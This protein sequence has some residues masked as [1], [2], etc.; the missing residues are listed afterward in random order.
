MAGFELTEHVAA[1]P[2]EVFA[3]FADFEGAPQRTSGIDKLE[4]LT[5]GPIGPGTRFRETRTMFG[6]QTTEELEIVAFDEGRSYS[7]RCESCGCEFRTR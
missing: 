6:R 2:A 1:P 7:V 4:V 3:V 5:E